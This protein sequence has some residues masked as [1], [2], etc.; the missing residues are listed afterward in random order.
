[1]GIS[2]SLVLNMLGLTCK[3]AQTPGIFD[4]RIESWRFTSGGRMRGRV[5][6]REGGREEA[7]EAF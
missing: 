6:E 1:M 2:K 4:E 3:G 7:N 5:R